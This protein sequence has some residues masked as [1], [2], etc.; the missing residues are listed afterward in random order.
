MDGEND[1]DDPDW[2]FSDDSVSDDCD[3]G[4]EYEITDNCV[5]SDHI[6]ERK[7]VVFESCLRQLF[8]LCFL[9]LSPCRIFIKRLFG[10]YVA[11][12]QRCR[13]GHKYVWGS[14]PVH[15]MMP[16]G[17]ILV[18]ASI[19]FT[20]SSPVR[21]L[22]MFRTLRIP[23][24]AFRTYNLMQSSYLIP[25]VKKVWSDYQNDLLTSMMDTRCDIS[26]DA[27]CCSPGHT[28]KFGSYTVMDIH[29]SKVLDVKLVQV[30]EVKNS[31]AME[32][33]GLKRCLSF[34]LQFLTIGTITTDRHP[35]VKKYLRETFSEIVH[36]FDV[37]HISKGIK[38][39]LESVSKRRDC[40]VLH[41]WAQAIS[42]HLY[43]CA[44]SS[45]GVGD[46]VLA[47]W[48]SIVRHVCNIHTGH[49]PLFSECAHGELEPR[50]WLL[51]GSKAHKEL[52]LI[53]N[54][55]QLC[56]DIKQLAHL[57]QTSALESFHKIVTFFAPKNVHYFY[58]AM[59]ARIL[60]AALHFNENSQ[61]PQA[62]TNQGQLQ[63][64]LSFP[65]ARKGQAVVKPVTIQATFAYVDELMSVTCE[66]RNQ[67]P[68][69]KSASENS[70]AQTTAEPKP[71]AMSLSRP[72]K[73]NAVLL[74]KTRF[75]KQLQHAED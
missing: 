43:W 33:E 6:H 36:F 31:N 37:W 39:K 24:I 5:N 16:V 45:N 48:C 1:Q 12:E 56:K 15:G 69:Y 42:N 40:A 13:H 25:A 34:L 54:N 28:A 17:N 75:N 8:L 44:A 50:L 21:V 32:L 29:S 47:K 38:N 9:C 46:V 58:S 66:I 57:G 10:S 59:E 74:H 73:E 52:E 67:F 35:C 51:S 71:V 70:K 26:G 18:A 68:T 27:R 49:G 65:K 14:Q 55:K 61:R 3:T 4:V 41:D 23:V 72:D 2:S 62:T 11:I 7:F 20:G 60:L 30:S 64:A 19:F 22:N 53:V 63:W